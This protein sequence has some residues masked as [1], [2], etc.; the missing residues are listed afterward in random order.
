MASLIR[1][2]SVGVFITICRGKTPTFSR[3]NLDVKDIEAI[4]EEAAED[5]TV[6][7]PPESS[8]TEK[9]EKEIERDAETNVARTISGRQLRI[10]TWNGKGNIVFSSTNGQC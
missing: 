2:S 9:D 6:T 4:A 7:P 10:V 1:N 5:A 3:Q 8:D